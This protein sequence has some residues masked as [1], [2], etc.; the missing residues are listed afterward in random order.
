MPIV[1]FEGFGADEAEASAIPPE[2]GKTDI[3]PLASQPGMTGEQFAWHLTALC[4]MLRWLSRQFPILAEQCRSGVGGTERVFP[5]VPGVIPSVTWH[6]DLC[7]PGYLEQYQQLIDESHDVV[8]LTNQVLGPNWQDWTVYKDAVQIAYRLSGLWLTENGATMPD[9][10][11]VT[12]A[13]RDG[14]PAVAQGWYNTVASFVS[15]G[16]DVM[17][18]DLSYREQVARIEMNF[19]SHL[20]RIY[21]WPQEVF[22]SAL[23]YLGDFAKAAIAA[24]LH[25]AGDIGGA[26]AEGL[27]SALWK[28]LKPLI[29]PA[30]LVGAGFGV[31]HY[32][33]QIAGSFE[34]KA[35]K[36]GGKRPKE[37]PAAAEA[38]VEAAVDGL[39]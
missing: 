24:I 20:R 15:L 14:W 8:A 6:E 29:I 7:P 12:P 30:L 35:F 17:D 26:A 32:R 10:R 3:A 31:Y 18:A 16:Q 2:A 34:R 9:G 22:A 23:N 19:W 28:I 4:G 38:P 5:G 39:W 25:A 36:A 11:P 13:F 1:E 33:H 21:A 27:A 37:V